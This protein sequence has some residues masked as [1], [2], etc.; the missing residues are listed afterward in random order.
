MSATSREADATP[1][2]APARP[3]YAGMPLIVAQQR[4][5]GATAGAVWRALTDPARLA[6]WFAD[7][8]RFA[9]QEPFRFDFGDGDFF[10]GRVTAWSAARELGLAWRF[11]GVG[12]RFVVTYRL[13]AQ[14]T[15]FTRVEVTDH[16]A[17]ITSE[18]VALEE[19]WADFL[20][21]LDRHVCLGGR[22]RFAWN[23][24]IAFG[25]LPLAERLAALA[26]PY[27]LDRWFPTAT[28]EVV[29]SAG[30]RRVC[31]REPHWGSLSTEARIERY[32]VEGGPYIAIT[33]D[34]WNALPPAL[35]VHER[36]RYAGIW[37]RAAAS[38]EGHAS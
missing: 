10:V 27:W 18:A 4:V 37:Q 29:E 38:L 1:R 6:E 21:R 13:V 36:R 23:P 17:P 7:V 2:G 14:E 32:D 35:R 28:C 31:F 8:D 26:S 34:G 16:G 9:D 22:T 24:I 30:S 3:A 20:G 15:G 5:V 11:M 19:G 12:P 33:H 25:A